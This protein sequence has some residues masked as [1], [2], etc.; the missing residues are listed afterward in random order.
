[1]QARNFGSGGGGFGG[2]GGGGK[3]DP[4]NWGSNG[5]NKNSGDGGGWS[6]DTIFSMKDVSSRTRE[7]LTRVYAALLTSTGSCALGMYLNTTV[8]LTGFFAMMLYMIGFAFCTY[9][10]RNP[11][12]SANTQLYY[13]FALAFAMGCMT[14]PGINHLAEVNPQIVTQAAIY[15]TGAFGSFSAVSLFS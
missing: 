2:G 5:P 3:D 9:Q 11:A 15:S 12:N 7:H 13:L 10:V 8:F 1:M 6:L 14:G 4:N